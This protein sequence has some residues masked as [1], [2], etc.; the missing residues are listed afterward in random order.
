MS[1]VIFLFLSQ[2][3]ADMAQTFEQNNI[4]PKTAEAFDTDVAAKLENLKVSLFLNSVL[5]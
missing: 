5:F 2:A 1:I 4:S 3:M